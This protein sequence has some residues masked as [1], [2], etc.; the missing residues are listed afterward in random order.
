MQT[1]SGNR[2]KIYDLR[3]T[4]RVQGWYSLGEMD[5]RDILEMTMNREE[6]NNSFVKESRLRARM[7]EGNEILS[8]V[9]AS[10]KTARTSLRS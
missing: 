6:M 7:T 4:S 10:A 8:I 1:Q 2:G 9:V 3:F 5:S